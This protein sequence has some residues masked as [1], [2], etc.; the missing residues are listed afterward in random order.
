MRGWRGGKG[1]G[2]GSYLEQGDVGPVPGHEQDGRV[3]AVPP[4]LKVRDPLCVA[5]D[6]VRHAVDAFMWGKTSALS[7]GLTR[8]GGRT[9]GRRGRKRGGRGEGGT[10]QRRNGHTRDLV[11]RRR[12]LLGPRLERPHSQDEEVELVREVGLEVPDLAAE[13]ERTWACV[14]AQLQGEWMGWCHH[15][16]RVVS[17]CRRL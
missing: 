16:G 8:A 4:E 17:G 14:S 10:G 11:I 6:L 2:R 12:I 15:L 7:S 3:G 9:G 13:R 1:E 5:P